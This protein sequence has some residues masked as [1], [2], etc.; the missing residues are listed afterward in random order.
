MRF[1]HF[2]IGADQGIG[3]SYPNEK[4]ILIVHRH[5]WNLLKK[6]IGVA[7]LFI[8]PIII[9]PIAGAFFV[10]AN[11]AQA[12]AA[13]GFLG[14]LWALFCWHQLFMRW[15]DYYY[16]IWIITNWRIVDMNLEGLFHV[17]IGSMLDLDHI[18][19]ITST[20]DGILQNLLGIGTVYI[21]TAATKH[22]EFKFEDVGRPAMIENMIRKAQ[23]E[24]HS[25]K[26]KAYD[27]NDSG[28]H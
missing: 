23:V 12:G 19:E 26:V 5:W 7:F 16:D 9:I 17:N 3:H 24:L 15:T 25:L 27:G 28:V 4:I 8:A 21:Q 11:A 2:T 10:G 13:F 14:A 18:Q 6:V 22:S 20:T 1:P